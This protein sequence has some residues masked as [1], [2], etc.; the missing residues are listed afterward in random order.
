LDPVNKTIS[1]K[2][3]DPLVPEAPKAVQVDTKVNKTESAEKME[4][5]PE[6]K[7]SDKKP[8]VKK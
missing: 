1:L 8:E 5:K 4:V 7:K 3:L 2:L 6:E